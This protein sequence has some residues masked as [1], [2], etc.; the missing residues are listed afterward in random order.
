MYET[1]GFPFE[2]TRELAYEKGVLADE[3]VFQRKFKEHQEKSRITAG[4]FKGGLQDHKE[5]TTKLHTA[6]H[7]L[8][9]ALREILGSHVLQKGS[10]I[11][12]ERLRFDFSHPQKMTSEEIQKIEE[13]V[14]TVIKADLP[15]RRDEMTVEEAKNYGAIGVFPE[16]Y[17]AI[18]KVYSVGS[19]SKEIC[20]GPHVEHT[21]VLGKFKIMKEE[22]VSQGVR[23]IKAI[24]T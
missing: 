22:A 14:N 6:T 19:F 20:G 1:Y 11:T 2:M 12:T 17:D 9:Q 7:L 3:E 13:L 16:R 23:R 24:L 18:V 15:V 5:E 8:H 21:S 10:N 4:I